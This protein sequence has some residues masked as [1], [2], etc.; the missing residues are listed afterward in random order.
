MTRF[1]RSGAFFLATALALSLSACDSGGANDPDPSSNPDPDPVEQNE[2]PTARASADTT[3][4]VVG[5]EV[6]LDASASNDPDGDALSFSWTLDAPAGSTAELSD[7]EAERPTFTPDVEGDYTA[8]VT[9]E[10]GNGQND[11]ASVTITAEQPDEDGPAEITIGGDAS[12][13]FDGYA[14]FYEGINPE[15]DESIFYIVLSNA[16]DETP[17]QDARGIWIA[18]LSGRPDVGQHPFAQFNDESEYDLTPDE[19]VS[20]A[21][22]V[23][24]DA[25]VLGYYYADGGTLTITHSSDDKVAGSFEINAVGFT[26]SEGGESLEEI[27]LSIEGTFDARSADAYFFP[28]PN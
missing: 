28:T 16:D 18:R 12:D 23:A 14:Y 27:N 13:S 20:F 17:D 4:V 2:A 5:T 21:W 3:A 10:D 7:S 25:S 6:T 24:S 8:T 1:L 15:T 22:S 9:V 11:D 19:F 26:L